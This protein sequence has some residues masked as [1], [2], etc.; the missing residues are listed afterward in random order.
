MDIKCRKTSCTHN[1]HYSCAA[2]DVVIGE[3]AECDSFESDITKMGTDY[4]KNMFEAETEFYANS[5]HIKSVNLDCCKTDC[6]FNHN[7]ECRANGITVLDDKSDQP[8][9]GTFIKE[10]D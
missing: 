4:S 2:R 3:N 8:Q 1:D 5:R 9:C 10:N 6:L 7:L